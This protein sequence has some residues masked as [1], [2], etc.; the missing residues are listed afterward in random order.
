MPPPPPHPPPLHHITLP[1]SS[2]PLSL[3][4]PS[5]SSYLSLSPSSIFFFSSPLCSLSVLL[6]PSLPPSLCPSSCAPSIPSSPSSLNSL[7]SPRLTLPPPIHYY[8]PN[9][10]SLS[11]LHYLSRHSNVARQV[12]KTMRQARTEHRTKP[13]PSQI[14]AANSD[15]SSSHHRGSVARTRSHADGPAQGR[16]WNGL[17]PHRSGPGVQVARASGTARAR[18]EW[19]RLG[20]RSMRKIVQRGNMHPGPKHLSGESLFP[21]TGTSSQ[22][23]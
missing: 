5:S 4:P 18:I 13:K 6:S 23:I 10:V 11:S 21:V 1:R 15:S 19:L 2:P 9:T 16:T 20:P 12:M 7:A 8:P 17:A 14:L 3:F 22:S